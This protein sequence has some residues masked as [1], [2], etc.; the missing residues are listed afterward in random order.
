MNPDQPNR[1]RLNSILRAVIEVA[2]ILFLS[3]SVRMMEEFKA[4]DGPGKTFVVALADSFTFAN[5]G[6]A[7]ISA[8]IGV[9]M[10]EYLRRK[11]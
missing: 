3:Y 10:F 8:L 5:F 11:S 7:I 9:A 2:L 6:I 4:S 1:P